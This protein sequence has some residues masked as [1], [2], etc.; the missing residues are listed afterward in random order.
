MVQGMGGLALVYTAACVLA[1]LA[2]YTC[3]HGLGGRTPGKML[4]GLRVIQASGAPMTPGLAFLRWVGYLISTLPFFLGFLWIA[5]DRRKQGWHDKLALTVVVRDKGEERQQA[6]AEAAAGL[7][8]TLPA[9]AAPLG[10]PVATPVVA[11]VAAPAAAEPQAPP[12]AEMAPGIAGTGPAASAESTAG[13]AETPSPE[14]PP[15]AMPAPA[16]TAPPE[17][18]PPSPEAPWITDAA[19]DGTQERRN[20]GGQPPSV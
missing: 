10:V 5:L 20:P 19:A 4:L 11:P 14:Q 7:P 13:G 18:L 1:N 9:D 17:S 3:F 16:A 8:A 12:L 15:A 6:A 2:Y